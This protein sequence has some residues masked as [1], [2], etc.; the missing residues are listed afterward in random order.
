MTT[1]QY[2]DR[3][4]VGAKQNLN[5]LRYQER[6]PAERTGYTKPREMNM[7][8]FTTALPTTDKQLRSQKAKDKMEAT[9]VANAAR[10]ALQAQRRWDERFDKAVK[11]K[12]RVTTY[13]V[14]GSLEVTRAVAKRLLAGW[15]AAGKLVV[16]ESSPNAPSVYGLAS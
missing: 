15:V 8:A 12:E 7:P 16:L 11:G 5:M 9:R 14:M 1:T 10:M 6:S 3:H 4:T 2:T 13:T